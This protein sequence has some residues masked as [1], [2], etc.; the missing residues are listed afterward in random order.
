MESKQPVVG[1]EYRQ[2]N[3]PG[4]GVPGPWLRINAVVGELVAYSAEYR[5][6][7]WIT[8]HKWDQIAERCDEMLPAPSDPKE[9][10]RG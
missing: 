4:L 10:S 3:V 9:A 8:R 5:G 6:I 1:E 7:E 2:S